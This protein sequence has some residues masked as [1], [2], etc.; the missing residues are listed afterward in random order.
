MDRHRV[1]ILVGTA[2]LVIAGLPLLYYMKFD[3]DPDQSAQ[4]ERSNRSRPISN[5]AATRRPT[6]TL[7][8]CSAP[9]L[10]DAIK[11]AEQALQSAGGRPRR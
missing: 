8:A 7:S 6:P 2:A 10:D 1:A 5:S 4:P 3:F 11:I 9:S